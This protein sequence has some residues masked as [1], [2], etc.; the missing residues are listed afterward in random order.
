MAELA[1]QLATVT[2]TAAAARSEL[3]EARAAWDRRREELEAALA[4]VRAEITERTAAETV[5]RTAIEDELDRVRAAHAAGRIEIARLAAALEAGRTDTDSA[6]ADRERL[7]AEVEIGRRRLGLSRVAAPRP[8][9]ARARGGPRRRPPG[10]RSSAAI[11]ARAAQSARAA[12]RPSCRS[13]TV[14]SSGWCAS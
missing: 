4:A 6:R 5:A 7:V 10:S 12:R 2:G 11:A 3:A 1:A 8:R 13:G 9:L 14:R